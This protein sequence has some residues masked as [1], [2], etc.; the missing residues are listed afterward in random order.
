M[1]DNRCGCPHPESEHKNCAV[2]Q[3]CGHED[4]RCVDGHYYGRMS[5]P[6]SEAAIRAEL[7]AHTSTDPLKP[8]AA[9]LCKLGSIVIH[10]EEFLSPT[11]HHVDLSAMRTLFEDKELRQWIKDMGPMLPVKR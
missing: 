7:T 2:G 9:L 4:C 5:D 6:A 3:Y 10:A 8:S 11:G 1:A